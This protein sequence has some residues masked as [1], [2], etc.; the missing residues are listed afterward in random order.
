MYLFLLHYVPNLFILK[1]G[2]PSLRWHG[3]KKKIHKMYVKEETQHPD[4]NAMLPQNKGNV[5]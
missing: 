1:Q 4:A 5:V 3:M 2:A